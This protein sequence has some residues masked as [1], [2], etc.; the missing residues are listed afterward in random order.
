MKEIKDNIKTD[1]ADPSNK[2]QKRRKLKGTG[3]LLVFFIF[4]FFVLILFWQHEPLVSIE[5]TPEIIASKPDVIMLSAWWCGTCHHAKSY[6]HRN[7]IHYCAYD[8]ENSSIGRELHKKHGSGGVPILLIGEHRLNGFNE[9]HIE[10]A[11]ALLRKN[12]N[13]LR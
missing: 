1:N 10:A 13:E 4:A 6:F 5:C 8:I 11:L 9:Q 7:N 12:N 3:P 2:D